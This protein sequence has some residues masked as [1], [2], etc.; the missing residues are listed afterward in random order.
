MLPFSNTAR[1]LSNH[2]EYQR[3]DLKTERTNYTTRGIEEVTLRKVEVQIHGFGEKQII[4]VAEGRVLWSQRKVRESG[5]H[6]DM[7]KEDTTLKPWARKIRGAD[8]HE[9]REQCDSTTGVFEILW[10]GCY[11]DLEGT[12]LLLK[13]KQSRNPREDD[14][15]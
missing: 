9:F 6:S 7:H 3:V 14:T 13:R 15:I 4:H 11:R 8:F 10:F 1:L 12:A 2:S 5:T